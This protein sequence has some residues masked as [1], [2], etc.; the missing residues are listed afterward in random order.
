MNTR[1]F[2]F[3]LFTIFLSGCAAPIKY[4]MDAVAQYS[5]KLNNLGKPIK[6]A[7][8]SYVQARVGMAEGD[9]RR[10]LCI[11]FNSAFVFREIEDQ[12]N[13]FVGNSTVFHYSIIDGVG[14]ATSN[15]FGIKQ[16]IVSTKVSSNGFTF[17]RTD[18]LGID[19][20]IPFVFMEILKAKN[21]HELKEPKSLSETHVEPTIIFNSYQKKK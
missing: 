11:A 21:I 2:Y 10:G 20:E 1:F 19:S 12:T 17:Q 7:N 13:S 14:V 5:G 6:Y 16:L 9:R 4:D 3:V 8:C 18:R 15:Y